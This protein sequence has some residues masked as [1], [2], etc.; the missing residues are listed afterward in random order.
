MLTA[1]TVDV[2]LV[3][4]MDIFHGDAVVK[5]LLLLIGEVAEAIPCTFSFVYLALVPEQG[6]MGGEHWLLPCELKDQVSSLTM[7]G[8]FW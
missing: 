2:A 7:R 8:C 4:A 3:F 1:D 5:L 6:K